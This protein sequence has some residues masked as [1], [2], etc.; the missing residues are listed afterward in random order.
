[1]AGATIAG[2]RLVLPDGPGL[3]VRRR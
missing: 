3:G 2:G 1:M